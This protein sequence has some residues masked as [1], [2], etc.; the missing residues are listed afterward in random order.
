MFYIHMHWLL[1]YTYLHKTFQIYNPSHT[2][3]KA[4]ARRSLKLWA[5]IEKCMHDQITPFLHTISYFL[6][7]EF[8]YM[9]HEFHLFYIHIQL[10]C[11]PYIM[12]PTPYIL[13]LKLLGT[14]SGEL[15]LHDSVSSFIYTHYFPCEVLRPLSAADTCIKTGDI[16][17]LGDTEYKYQQYPTTIQLSL[18]RLCSPS[19]W[20]DIYS[21]CI[22]YLADPIIH[23]G[24]ISSRA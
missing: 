3:I 1:I 12:F 7:E 10:Y 20:G 8:A 9:A 16:C 18:N 21:L 17:K 13:G 4:K 2:Y 23:P 22:V 24:R 11:A 15:Q 19:L 5:Y 6:R 14:D